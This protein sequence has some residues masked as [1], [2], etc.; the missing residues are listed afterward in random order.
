M[1]LQMFEPSAPASHLTGG[2][3]GPPGGSPPWGCRRP[4]PY[5]GMGGYSDP[6]MSAFTRSCCLLFVVRVRALSSQ[7][8]SAPLFSHTGCCVSLLSNAHACARCWPDQQR[9][10][11]A[12]VQGQ[13]KQACHQCV[14][15]PMLRLYVS[16]CHICSRARHGLR[17]GTGTIWPSRPDA[18]R[19]SLDVKPS[20]A[21]AR[22][23]AGEPG[24]SAVLAAQAA[25]SCA[26][27]TDSTAWMPPA[28]PRGWMSRVPGSRP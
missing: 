13:S 27:R 11:S 24:N 6:S 21:P 12:R 1:L 5:H 14:R 2:L 26:M 18:L 8:L 19:R 22:G 9:G 15:G 7:L 25:G 4:S 23:P 17:P 16:A 10:C 20:H 28:W 3:E